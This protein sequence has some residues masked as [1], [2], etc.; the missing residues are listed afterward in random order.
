[1]HDCEGKR[2]DACMVHTTEESK[3]G[4]KEQVGNEKNKW[5]KKRMIGTLSSQI[6]WLMLRTYYATCEN[7]TTDKQDLK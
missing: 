4:R 7:S 1:M 2:V 5:L 6:A 3:Q